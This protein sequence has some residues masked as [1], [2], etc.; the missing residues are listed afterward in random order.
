VRDLE[1]YHRHLR[2]QGYSPATL[3]LLLGVV[4]MACED[5]GCKPVELRPADVVGFLGRDLA[6]ATRRGYIWALRAYASWADL[7]DLCELVRRPRAPRAV[8]RPCSEA[9]LRLLL[10]ASTGRV[11]AWVVLGAYAGLRSFESAKV[12]GRDF[13]GT[14]EGPALRV[15]GKGGRVDVLPVPAF[16]TRELRPWVEAAGSGRL[17]P[18]ARGPNVQSGIARAAARAGVDVSSHQL[19]HRYG[20][21]LY[22]ASR[23]LLVVQRLMR[24]AS[25]VTTAGYAQVTDHAGALLVDR[26]P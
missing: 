10:E 13:E 2:A 16:L 9:D 12:C 24:H 26:L 17:W 15:Q 4:R 21:Q 25:P 8:P 1:D 11:R 7:G 14:P 20:T 23:D 5:A 6:P 18:G 19:R 22:A 3:R